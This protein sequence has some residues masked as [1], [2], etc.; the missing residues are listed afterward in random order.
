MRPDEALA[1]AHLTMDFMKRMDRAETRNEVDKI[2]A[3]FMLWAK[4]KGVAP[5]IR[6]HVS[7]KARGLAA[8]LSGKGGLSERSKAMAGDAV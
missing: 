3:E 2:L 1:L 6:D 5:Q 8:E 7:A 4:A